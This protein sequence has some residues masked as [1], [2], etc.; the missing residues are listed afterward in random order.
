MRKGFKYFDKV[1]LINLDIREDRLLRR[2]A[3]FE[4]NGVNDIVER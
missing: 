1:F 2:R 3:F 4:S